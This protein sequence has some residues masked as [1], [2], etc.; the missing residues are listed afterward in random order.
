MARTKTAYQYRDVQLVRANVDA[1]YDPL[2]SIPRFQALLR[3]MNF[4]K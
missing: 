4:P 2:R 1:R 3:L